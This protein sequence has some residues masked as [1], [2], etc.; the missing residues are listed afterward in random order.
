MAILSYVEQSGSAAVHSTFVDIYIYMSQITAWFSQFFAMRHLKHIKLTSPW[1]KWSVWHHLVL[2]GVLNVELVAGLIF[3][4]SCVL[5][6]PLLC[7]GSCNFWKF[8]FYKV[9][10]G[11]VLGV[12]GSLMVVLSQIFQRVYQW[13]NFQNLLRIDKV[14]DVSC[15]SWS[16]F[17]QF[18][19]FTSF[20]AFLV[21]FTT[22]LVFFQF[23]C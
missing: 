23:M 6:L 16:Y 8:I 18:V 11:C 14:I 2:L 22:F 3:F 21:P 19:R 12:L 13:K 7:W 15:C 9:V 4:S 20:F 17:L 10:W 1:K 5:S